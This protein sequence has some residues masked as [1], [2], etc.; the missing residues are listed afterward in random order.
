MFFSVQ[1][2]ATQPPPPPPPAPN[3]PWRH[4]VVAGSEGGGQER[5]LPND[6]LYNHSGQQQPQQRGRQP[7]RQPSI[8]NLAAW[9]SHGYLAKANDNS[10]PNHVVAATSNGGVNGS[11]CDTLTFSLFQFTALLIGHWYKWLILCYVL[12]PM[13]K[14]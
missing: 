14:W 9:S 12:R 4:Q 2:P 5:S 10:V 8:N 6:S 11:R 3:K 7:W 1:S 13:N